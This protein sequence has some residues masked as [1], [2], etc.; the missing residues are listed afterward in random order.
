MKEGPLAS[1]ILTRARDAW[2]IVGIVLALVVVLE[3]GYRTQALARRLLFGEES[4]KPQV[5]LDVTPSWWDD[6]IAEQ[7]EVDEA[8]DWIPYV[9][10]AHQRFVGQYM[11]IDD[12]GVRTTIQP[13]ADH[14]SSRTVFFFGGSTVWGSYQRDETTIPSL[15]AKALAESG[16]QGVRVENYGEHNYVLDQ[17]IHR[18]VSLLRSGKRPSVVVFYD[19]IDDVFSSVENGSAGISGADVGRYR[20]AMRVY[21]DEHKISDELGAGAA[22]ASGVMERMLLVSRV[23]SAFRG[24]GPASAPVPAREKAMLV[25]H[26][27]WESVR[28][29]EALA[30]AYGFEPIFVWQPTIYRTK[31]PLSPAEARIRGAIEGTAFDAYLN[32]L[33]PLVAEQLRLGVRWPITPRFVDLTGVFNAESEQMYIDIYGHTTARANELIV[34]RLEPYLIGALEASLL[35][36][37]GPA[38]G[39]TLMTT[40]EEVSETSD[41]GDSPSP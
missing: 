27:Y 24:D 39:P 20:M 30:D 18:L 3:L 36:E 22:I 41:A 29:A 23:T 11:T 5:V 16:V 38:E 33:H 35:R 28:I 19:G 10:H 37:H 8:V 2:V 26:D 6:L 12:E 1:K 21:N 25:A 14:P 9:F 4:F 13:E 31:K 32:E 17:E 15:A 40:R 7:D 34:E